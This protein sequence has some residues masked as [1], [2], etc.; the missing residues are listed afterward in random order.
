MLLNLARAVAIPAVL[1][2][3]LV[4][5]VAAQGLDSQAMRSEGDGRGLALGL[6][7]I[8][9]LGLLLHEAEEDEDEEREARERRQRTLPARCLATWRTADG[10]ATLYDPDCLEDR[11]QAADRLPLACAVTVRSDRRFVSGFSPACLRERGWR[12]PQ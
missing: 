12:T 6:A 2:A 10:A 11:F 1:S 7:A 4:Q 3:V 5:P 8:A 9:A